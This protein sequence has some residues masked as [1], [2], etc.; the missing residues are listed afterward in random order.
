MFTTRKAAEDQLRELEGNEAD[1]YLRLVDTF[2]EDEVNE[3]WKDDDEPKFSVP[4]RRRGSG[5]AARA[6]RGFCGGVEEA[7]RRESAPPMVA[8]SVW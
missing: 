1:N 6:S 8:K 2:G 4:P 3:D 7:P 5:G